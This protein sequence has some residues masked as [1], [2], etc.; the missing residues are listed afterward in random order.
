MKRKIYVETSVIS[1]LTARPSKTIIGAA[2]Q[3]IT[4]A[5]WETRSEFE[6]FVSDVVLDEC[7]DGNTEAAQRRV[8]AIK[9]IPLLEVTEPAV[10]VARELILRSIV[11]RKAAQDALHIAVA[12]IHGMDCLLTW[13][14]RHIANID[15]QRNVAHYLESIGL[16]LPIMCTPE[17]LLGGYDDEDI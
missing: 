10:E 13:N 8:N 12:T 6:L 1:Y 7:A 17:E 3:Q 11:P 5:W 15:I 4:Q 16:L 14:C 9:D 2:H